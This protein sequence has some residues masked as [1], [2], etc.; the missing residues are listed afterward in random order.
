MNRRTVLTS[1]VATSFATGAA[2]SA[3]SVGVS[4]GDRVRGATTERPPVLR[5][6]G[7]STLPPAAAVQAAFDVRGADRLALAGV[8]RRLTAVISALAGR[9]AG[10]GRPV[11]VMVA[12]GASLF[13]GRFGLGSHRPRA[14]VVMPSFPNDVLDPARCHGDLLVQVCAGDVET[15]RSVLAELAVPGLVPRWRVEGFRDQNSVTGDGRAV[16]RNLFGFR[17]GAG[18]PDVRDAAEM[19]RLVWVGAD[20]GE[21]AWAVGGSYQVVRIIRFATALWDGESVARQEAV[22]G[23]RKSDGAP[24]GL[25]REDAVFDYGSDPSGQVI[26]LDAHIRRANPRTPETAGSRIL[27]RGYSYRGGVDAAGRRDEG[28]LFICFQRDVEA[29]FATMQ[30]RLAGEALDRYVLPVGG[31]YFFVLPGVS[32]G[33]GDYLGR[34]LIDAAG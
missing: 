23:R 32:G 33:D 1:V 12:V 17:D 9:Y 26:A 13:D 10:L 15:V 22:F 28:M 21:P 24:L 6:P 29:G 7:V 31:G 20:A 8:L 34:T 14:L 3:C 11:E 18:N 27:R 4:D 30:R 19:E 16:D 2:L 25:D 5:Q